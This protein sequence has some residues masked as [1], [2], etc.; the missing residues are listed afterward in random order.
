[1]ANLSSYT[2]IV[3]AEVDDTSERAKAVIQRALKDTYQEIL[4][5]CHRYLVGTDTYSTTAVAGTQEYTPTAFYEVIRVLWH[6]A[7]DTDFKIL[8]EITEEEAIEK[9]YNSENGTPHSFYRNAQNVILV[10]TPDNA[11]TLEVVYVPVQAELS[12]A[13]TSLIPDR[14]TNVIVIGAIARFKMYEGVP[15]AIE[16]QAKYT[17]AFQDM[18]K[19]LITQFTPIKPTFF[20]R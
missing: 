6:D 9:Y 11:G 4:K 7:G 13:I 10:P 16:Y 20:G 19:E 18:K 2:T 15:E 8:K 5:H 12:D 14:Y 17:A 3:Q 1:M